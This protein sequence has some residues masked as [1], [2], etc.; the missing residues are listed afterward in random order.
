MIRATIIFSG[1]LMTALF[2]DAQDTLR[3]REV[4]ITSTFKPSLKEAAKI[5]I[6]AAP[7]T[8]DTSLP[9]LQYNIPNQNLSFMFQP[10]TLK[11]LALDADTGGRWPNDNYVKLGY[12]NFKT[13]FAQAGFSFGDGRNMGVNIYAK[14][15]SSDGKLL[16]Q[17]MSHTNVDLKAF[18]KTS[19]NLEWNAALGGMQEK[20]NKYGSE[21][22]LVYP[23]D[24]F[25]V[26]LQT[27]SGRLGFH[28]INRTEL[29]IGF[30]P[31]VRVDAFNDRDG[32]SESNSYISV[33]VTKPLGTT[34][35]VEVKLEANISRYS[36]EDKEK[37]TNNWFAFS[38]SVHYNSSGLSI[39]AGLRPSWENKNFK[40]FPN[41]MAEFTLPGKTFSVQAG[42]TGY[43]KY[44]GYQV[45]A[46][47]NPWVYAPDQTFNTSVE[48]RYGGFKGSVGDHFTY[49]AKLSYNSYKNQPLFINDTVS[50]GSFIVLNEPEMNVL[51]IGGE[52]GYTVGEKFSMITT[53]ALNQYSTDIS[54]KA[55]GLIPL[56][57]N[58]RLRLQV[59]K[60][61][62]ANANVYAFDGPW[63]LNKHGRENLKGSMDL[64]AGLEF[65]V[66]PRVKVWMQFNNIL[67]KEYE[68]WNQYPVYGLNF[69]GGVVLSFAQNK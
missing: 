37:V 36:P 12:G 14:H 35:G 41:L 48:E 40:L 67:G 27:W 28:N 3:R 34:F 46:G 32:N 6:N 59:L 52:L 24:S 54:E 9:R 43:L 62:Y 22:L 58:T 69:L 44:S 18:F 20:Y 4:N 26:K 55:W 25:K 7:P 68:R 21:K 10:G 50:G 30:S 49:G 47:M 13:P 8:A 45:V 63:S 65:K 23:E 60:D 5:N 64:S 66:V 16:L 15:F 38:P 56:E 39:H 33:P 57:F 11:P 19:K 51:N 2:A 42:W 53:V 61:L 17:E 31:E 1:L 29:G